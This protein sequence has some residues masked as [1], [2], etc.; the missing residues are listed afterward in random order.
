[1]TQRRLDPRKLLLSKWTAAQPRDRERHFLVIQLIRDERDDL[2]AVELQ[3]VVSGRS[4]RLDWHE[5]K[6]AQ[7]WLQGWR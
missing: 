5:L 4:Q 2:L 7:R 3:A 6:D 1:M